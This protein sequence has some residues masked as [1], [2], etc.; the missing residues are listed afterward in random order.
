M[1]LVIRTLR[2]ESGYRL[3]FRT[4]SGSMEGIAEEPGESSSNQRYHL[5]V[6][7][8]DRVAAIP[9]NLVYMTQDFRYF[10]PNPNDDETRDHEGHHPEEQQ[11]G[12]REV[13]R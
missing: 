6:F 3:W 12:V 2:W 4:P 11:G 13:P 9:G 10:D 5:F 7:G 8:V 1:S